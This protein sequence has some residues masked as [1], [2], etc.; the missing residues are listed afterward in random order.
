MSSPIL[1]DP[2]ASRWLKRAVRDLE[3]RDIVDA[4]RDV[5][6][7]LAHLGTRYDAVRRQAEHLDRTGEFEHWIAELATENLPPA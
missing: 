3:Q 2:T 4:I 6:V 5:E 7:L 1:T